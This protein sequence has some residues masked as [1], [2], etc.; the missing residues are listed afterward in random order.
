MQTRGSMTHL[1]T[2]CILLNSL[3]TCCLLSEE[4][5]R[6]WRRERKR[7]E[8]TMWNH[9][10]DT[11]YVWEQGRNDGARASHH[12]WVSWS[13]HRSTFPPTP[14]RESLASVGGFLNHRWR[15]QV[16]RLIHQV[17][18]REKK[19]KKRATNDDSREVF[20]GRFFWALQMV[21]RHKQGVWKR[22]VKWSSLR[23][24]LQFLPN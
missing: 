1:V 9:N 22:S 15:L 5:R 3:Q 19:K 18:H 8:E 12:V 21:M 2:R 4:H 7:R 14:Q 6:V 16:L 20:D 11:G 23:D 10:Q 24:P 13:T 17:S